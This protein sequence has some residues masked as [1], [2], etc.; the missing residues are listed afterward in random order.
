MLPAKNNQ[1]TGHQCQHA[2]NHVHAVE[3]QANQADQPLRYQPYPQQQNAYA[4]HAS[5]PEKK[6]LFN[7]GERPPR[8]A[9]AQIMQEHLSVTE[10]TE[11]KIQNENFYVKN[12]KK[13]LNQPID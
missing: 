13:H 3:T 2:H 11:R 4:F 9:E 5:A 6:S 12:S 7:H 8:K 10:S 1:N